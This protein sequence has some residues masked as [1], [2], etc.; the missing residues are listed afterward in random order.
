MKIIVVYS[1]DIEGDVVF[2]YKVFSFIVEK[3]VLNFLRCTFI[4]ISEM[5]V[6]IKI[7]GKLIFVFLYKYCYFFF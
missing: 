1:M 5:E 3:Y 4:F 2:E 7:L 6:S